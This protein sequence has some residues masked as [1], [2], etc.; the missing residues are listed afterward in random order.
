MTDDLKLLVEAA[1]AAG[2][3]VGW[4]D[5]GGGHFVCRNV[6]GRDNYP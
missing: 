5:E 6:P 3:Y 2:I 4:W 1:K